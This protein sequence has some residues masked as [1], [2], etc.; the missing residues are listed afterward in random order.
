MG[1]GVGSWA[2]GWELGFLEG[3]LENNI[4]RSRKPGLPGL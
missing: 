2:V 1:P 3:P 4:L